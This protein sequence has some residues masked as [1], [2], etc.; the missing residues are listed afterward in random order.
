MSAL[1]TGLGELYQEL[2]ESQG[3][4]LTL[5]IQIVTCMVSPH[6]LNNNSTANPG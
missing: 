1:L 2:A 3:K 5:H 4:H 6:Y